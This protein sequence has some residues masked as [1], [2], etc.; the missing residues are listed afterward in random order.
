M[1]TLIGDVQ[2]KQGEN[3]MSC[4]SAY[5]DQE[6]NNVEAFGNVH[7]IQPG[8]TEASSDYLRYIGNSKMAFMKGNVSLT[9][10]KNNLWTEELEYNLGTKV[11]V[12]TRGGTLQ[13]DGT[14][15][16]SNWGTYNVRLK[17]AR[18]TGEVYVNDPEY[19]VTS[20]DLGYN[21]ETKLVRFFAASVVVSDQSELR[22]SSGTWDGKNE[23]A[24]FTSRSSILNSGQYIEADKLDYERR[25]GFGEAVGNVF[26]KDSAQNTTLFSGYAA[27]NQRSRKLLA[28]IRPV[29]KQ[30]TQTDSLY[31][32]ADTFYSAPV[33]RDTDSTINSRQ[34]LGNK[35][36]EITPLAVDTTDAD[37][38]SPRYF[39]AYHHVLIYSDSL[40]ARCD[41]L[42]YTQADSVMRLMSSILVPGGHLPVAWSRRSQITGDTIYLYMDSS[43]LKKLYVPN[44]AFVVSRS[45]PD[46]AQMF[47]QIQGK[48]LIGHFEEGAIR[49]MIVWPG[50]EAIYYST[51]D[52]GAY[53]GVNEAQSERMRVLFQ[54]Q[55]IDKIVLE[56]EV[57]QVMTPL[58]QVSI[59]NMRLSRFLWLYDKRPQ[60]VQELFTYDPY[61]ASTSSADDT[62]EEPQDPPTGQ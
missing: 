44:N 23:I 38:T 7:I 21:T 3:F 56:Q 17:D 41:S 26:A 25:T 58:Q 59:Q 43:R 54:N 28:T 6:K 20:E 40:Q 12:Y 45:G 50:A 42:S 13:S 52:N 30:V 19:T 2:L 39:I 37:S 55:Q 4:D 49:E 61:K 16:S 51:D 47:D 9:D 14:T 31:I 8:G 34:A 24:H 18:F 48:S 53:L 46:K 27:Y 1:S 22:T 10:G 60:T 62:E 15:L 32:R 5:I 33:P 35:I 36:V 57:K 29:M 11:G